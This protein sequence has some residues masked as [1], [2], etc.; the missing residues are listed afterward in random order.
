MK[1][2]SLAR[3]EM[4]QLI[5]DRTLLAIMVYM[6][7]ADIYIAGSVSMEVSNVPIAVR[8]L[9]RSLASRLLI[10]RFQPPYFRLRAHLE[11]ERAVERAL[12]D[13]TAAMVLVIPED[14]SARLEQRR[15]AEVQMLADGTNS[16]LA[17]IA[18]GYAGEIVARFSSDYGG[19]EV[20]ATIPQVEAR[21]RVLF[22]PNLEHEL[23][24][25]LTELLIAVTLIAILLS[26]TSFV[27]E[28]EDG[29]IEQ[30]RV[31]PIRAWE[32]I[33]AKLIPVVVVSLV[34]IA[35]SLILIIE[36]VFHVPIR[37][38]LLLFFAASL[39]HVA[40]VSSIG[41][42]LATIAE[43]MM[44]ALLATIFVLAPML[45]LSGS[46]TP[47]ESMPAALRKVTYISPL[48]Y[49]FE[50]GRGIFLKGSTLAEL[51]PQ[52]AAL[53]FMGLL[54]YGATFGRFR[55]RYLM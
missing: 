9:D 36:P 53:F 37:G 26:S 55:R 6:F 52:F 29:T 42:A 7:T 4:V 15:P 49:Y 20:A 33:V 30:I 43:N 2:A 5:R 32:L 22:N 1:I 24:M 47:I 28:K 13:G 11:R 23:L 21:T 34:A 12:N 51:W 41:L 27:R 38:S 40:V 45:F 35:L 18:M 31:A 25:P 46:F 48:R 16:N 54:L 8:D 17:L 3:K 14:F 19:A 10:E 50:I 44:Q 39:L